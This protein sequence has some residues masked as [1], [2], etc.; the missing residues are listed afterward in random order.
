MTGLSAQDR[1]LLQAALTAGHAFENAFDENHA[2]AFQNALAECGTAASDLVRKL[3]ELAPKVDL[4]NGPRHLMA[5]LVPLERLAGRSARD[6]EFL[7]FEKDGHEG[8]EHS[9]KSQRDRRIV[10]CE[11]IRSAFN[12][13]SVYRTSET[14]GGS[15]VW[16]SGYT[17]DPLKTAMG[18]DQLVA[19]RRFERASDAIAE[20]KKLGFT[21]IA[22][23]NSPGAIPLEKFNWPEKTMLVLGNERFGIDS[24]TLA[25][26]DS[27]VRIETT[28]Q[29][30]SLNVGIAFGIAAS[31]WRKSK[32]ESIAEVVKPIGFVRGGYPNPQVAPRQGSYAQ[33][34]HQET[35]A[36]IELE[37]RFDGRPS[38]FEQ[39]LTDLEG[40]ERAWII[41]GFDR[42]EGWNPQVRPPRGDGQKRGLFATR[43]PHR[44][45]RLGISCVR[46]KSVRGRSVEIVEHD[47]LEGT[48]V[49]DI[50]PYVPDADAFPNANAGWV[51][52]VSLAQFEIVETE[53]FRKKIDW[54]TREGEGRLRP[55]ISEQLRYQPYDT[56]RKRL[57]IASEPTGVH[58]IAFRTWRID[59]RET[60]PRQLEI[61]DLRS[62]YS[63][64]E[65][66]STT[67]TFGDKELHRKFRKAFP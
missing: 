22:L 52:Q 36:I 16:L 8:T 45:N 44:P 13:G 61:V 35:P 41:F 12:V 43:S 6:E 56:D 58:T 18:T 49:Y 11:N 46:I 14:F 48:P 21:I 39:A 20:A 62:G 27:V 7:F 33:F 65:I 2:V 53:M 64:D 54:L 24:Q 26:C 67:D 19:T 30:N 66:N 15:E 37:M 51:D 60:S 38:N 25:S 4:R 5:L 50:K 55:F 31:S 9:E 23:E 29:K 42:C 40:F 57:E 10:L 59:F 34:A 47:L 63:E 17:P 28:G 3:S 32:R 1:K